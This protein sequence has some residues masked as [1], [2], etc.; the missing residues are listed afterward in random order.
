MRRKYRTNTPT[1]L[2]LQTKFLG[3]DPLLSLRSVASNSTANT[4]GSR[5]LSEGALIDSAPSSDFEPYIVFLLLSSS[6]TIRGPDNSIGE[7]LLLLSAALLLLSHLTSRNEMAE[8]AIATTTPT[9]MP[10]LAPVLRLD[11][12]NCGAGVAE[13]EGSPT[14]VGHV[15]LKRSSRLLSSVFPFSYEY[16]NKVILTHQ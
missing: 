11:S 1:S 3:L 12:E 4:A 13:E 14:A 16:I 8:K 15:V 5:F 10:A 9:P 2:D 6:C 7:L